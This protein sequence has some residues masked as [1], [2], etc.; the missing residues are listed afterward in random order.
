MKDLLFTT[1]V[2]L[3]LKRVKEHSHVCTNQKEPPEIF[4]PRTTAATKKTHSFRKTERG[5]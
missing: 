1:N 5:T 3:L 4:Q 2:D